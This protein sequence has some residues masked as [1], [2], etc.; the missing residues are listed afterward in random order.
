VRWR[1]QKDAR[2]FLLRQAAHV[3][4]PLD[5]C[6]GL[7]PAFFGIFPGINPVF[8]AEQFR[9]RAVAQQHHAKA[10][11]RF[12]DLAGSHRSPFK[13]SPGRDCGLRRP[14]QD[15]QVCIAQAFF[16]FSDE[17]L[18]EFDIDL[19][20]PRLNLLSF[21]L[22]SERLHEVLVF[23][24]VG[25]K[26]FHPVAPLRWA[27]LSLHIAIKGRLPDRKRRRTENRNQPN[28]I[29]SHPERK[30]A[31]RINVVQSRCYRSEPFM[32]LSS[33]HLSKFAPEPSQTAASSFQAWWSWRSSPRRRAGAAKRDAA[34]LTCSQM[35][36][37][38]TDL[39]AF[40]AFAALRLFN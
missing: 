7:Q 33:L 22:G 24:A 32:F 13:L 1:R 19:A 35:H 40:F 36:P 37:I 3:A 10:R 8:N 27:R 30:G 29:E 26:D 18:A 4:K 21:E 9:Y 6:H 14:K 2:R 17:I 16:D 5:P 31:I 28:S 15:G 20:K 23:R 12:G 34:C 25:K 39:H 38:C 11:P